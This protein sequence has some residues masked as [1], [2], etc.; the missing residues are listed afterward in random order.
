MA[1]CLSDSSGLLAGRAVVPP[2]VVGNPSRAGFG[3][4]PLLRAGPAIP[5]DAYVCSSTQVRDCL[6]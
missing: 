1:V 4:R 3:G 2:D 6:S 5:V